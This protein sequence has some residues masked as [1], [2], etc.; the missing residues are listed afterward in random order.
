[1]FVL[2][3]VSLCCCVSFF[4]VCMCF[5]VFDCAL[6]Y[7]SVNSTDVSVVALSC[8]CLSFQRGSPAS[9]NAFEWLHEGHVCVYMYKQST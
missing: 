6:R 2:I 7:C 9:Q 8:K 3:V 1:M 4:C 5:V